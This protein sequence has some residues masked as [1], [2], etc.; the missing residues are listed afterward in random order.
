MFIAL[1]MAVDKKEQKDG[2]E[3]HAGQP[4]KY[5][6]S[7][8]KQAQILTEK[9]FTDKEVAKVF[10]VTEQTINNWK[11]AFPQFFESLKKGKEIADA[12]VVRSLYQRALGYS[13]PEVHISNYQGVITKTSIIKHYPPD[14]TSL[15]F[16]LKNRDRENWRDKQEHEVTGE[17]TL[18]PPEVT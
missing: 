13:H 2:K 4:T 6:L 16:W 10:E 14:P 11:K 5:I 3:K 12:K 1:N 17:I 7:M 9:G 18:K 15:I 8:N